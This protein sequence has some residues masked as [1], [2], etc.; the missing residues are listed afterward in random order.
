MHG[1]Q[2]TGGGNEPEFSA[3]TYMDTFPSNNKSSAMCASC[4]C[5]RFEAKDELLKGNTANLTVWYPT[6]LVRSTNQETTIEIYAHQVQCALRNL[7]ATG[8]LQRGSC[9]AIPPPAY[10]STAQSLL[11]QQTPR[12]ATVTS[13]RL[14]STH[15]QAIDSPPSKIRRLNTT[16]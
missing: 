2:S 7:A 8:V 5:P 13:E 16:S 12:Y 10:P 15:L 11:L 9:F 14:R 1:I 3:H 6:L 4:K